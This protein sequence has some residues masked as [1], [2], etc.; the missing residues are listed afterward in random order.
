[1]AGRHEGRIPPCAAYL[2]GFCATGWRQ[3]G[4]A[5]YSPFRHPEASLARHVDALLRE[6]RASADAKQFVGVSRQFVDRASV[7]TAEP[8]VAHFVGYFDNRQDRPMPVRL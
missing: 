8:S 6:T 4:E 7:A 1:M 2:S 5:A 3:G